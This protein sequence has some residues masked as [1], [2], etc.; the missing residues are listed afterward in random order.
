MFRILFVIMLF[1]INS[2]FCSSQDCKG[3][4]EVNAGPDIDV[5]EDGTVGLSGTIGGD[6]TTA[7]WR[8]GNGVFSAGRNSLNTEYTPSADELGKGVVLILVANNPK[9]NCPP[10]RSEVKITVNTQPKVNAGGNQ[11]ICSGEKV[12]LNGN[13]SGKAKKTTWSSSGTG[14]FTDDNSLSTSYIPSEKDILSGGCTIQLYAKP[15]GVCIPDSSSLVLSIAPGPE[16]K[17]TS[18]NSST[19]KGPVRLSVNSEEKLL[20][21]EWS[22]DGSGKFSQSNGIENTYLVSEEDMKNEHINITVKGYSADCSA[23]KNISIPLKK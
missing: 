18:E 2:N 12:L 17:I 5:C 15:Y 19:K 14:K 20:K 6:A 3:N 7:T 4:F 23:T 8:G 22:S 11:R 9:M 13:V 1:V 21:T 10:A 16:F